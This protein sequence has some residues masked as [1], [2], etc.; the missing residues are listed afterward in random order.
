MKFTA[1]SLRSSTLVLNKFC[2]FGVFSG[3]YDSS[4]MLVEHPAGNPVYLPLVRKTE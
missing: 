2:V 3:L 1:S 4:E